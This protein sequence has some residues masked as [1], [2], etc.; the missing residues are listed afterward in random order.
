MKSY[1]DAVQWK[2]TLNS[3]DL[4]EQKMFE[5]IDDSDNLL[6]NRVMGIDPHRPFP[7]TIAI[8]Y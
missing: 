7:K 1:P 5:R 2:H 3:G 6:T 4:T 8:E